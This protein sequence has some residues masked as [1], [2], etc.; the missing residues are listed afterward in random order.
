MHNAHRL[1]TSLSKRSVVTLA[2]LLLASNCG[3]GGSSVPTAP[4][5]TKA[6]ISVISITAS[7]QRQTNSDLSYLVTFQVRESAGVAASIQNATLIV[8]NT[9]GAASATLT[10]SEALVAARLVGG[11]TV[12]SKNISLD[13]NSTSQATQLAVRVAYS[14]DEGHSGSAEGFGSITPAPAPPTPTPPTPT[15]PP[16]SWPPPLPPRSSGSH[17]VCQAT[18]PAIAAC[19]NDAVGPP[20]A[21]C[22]DGRYSCSTGSGTCS[23][24]G[25]VYCWRN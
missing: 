25:G 17:P 24:H 9:S 23:G 19:V 10:G 16:D 12:Q 4:T 8:S 7:T 15:P 6:A 21:V 3:G 5:P 22:E 1:N 18:L 13:T 11:G 20:Q 2:V 14:D